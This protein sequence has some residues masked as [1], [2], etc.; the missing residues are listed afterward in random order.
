MTSIIVFLAVALAL[1]IFV[2]LAGIAFAW[3]VDAYERAVRR[4]TR[5]D[6]SHEMIDGR[7]P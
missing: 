2:C 5:D 3:M 4:H 1:G 6:D 7:V